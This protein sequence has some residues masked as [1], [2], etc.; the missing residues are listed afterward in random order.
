MEKTLGTATYSPEDNKL[1]LYPKARLDANIY[2]RVKA[3]GF[4][5]APKQE[6]FVAPMWSPDR[7]DLLADLCGEIEPEEMTMAERA[8]LKAQRLTGYAEKRL[9]ERNAYHRAADRYSER[10]ANGQPILVGH[11]SERSA[12]VAQ[13]RV[14]SAMNQAAKRERVAKDHLYRAEGA[15]AHANHKNSDRVRAGR[16]ETLLKEYRD[17]CRDESEYRLAIET[18]EKCTNQAF[19]SILADYGNFMTYD[20]AKTLRDN[21]THW[22]VIKEARLRAYNQALEPG[23]RLNR[24]KEHIL[25]RLGYERSLLGTVPRYDGE[26]TPG[27]VQVFARTWGVDTPKAHKDGDEIGLTAAS[28][29]PPFISENE[30]GVTMSPE[31]W[32]DLFQAL[33]YEPPKKIHAKTAPPLL[34][35]DQPTLSC[36]CRYNRGKVETLEVVRVTKAQYAKASADYKGTRV[37][38]CGSYRFRVGIK[39][40]FM[41]CDKPAYCS[42]LVAVFLIDQKA[43]SLPEIQEAA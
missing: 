13:K 36:M 23:S 4:K 21:P 42:P 3:A 12:R 11:H 31:A 28:P 9:Q 27:V 7:E 38:L 26:V 43:H 14:E 41:P 15:L 6:L 29:L 1:R 33:G 24:W 8:E 22:Q 34:N 10:F 25:N 18:W 35:L 2:E 20:Q 16:I 40:H 39:R 37:S 19:A 17:K 32:L 5:W 30:A